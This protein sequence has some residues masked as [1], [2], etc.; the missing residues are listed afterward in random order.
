MTKLRLSVVFTVIVCITG[1]FQEIAK[2]E[3]YFG[4]GCAGSCWRP[5]LKEP[6]STEDNSQTS[7]NSSSSAERY[8]SAGQEWLRKWRK[9]VVTIGQDQQAEEQIKTAFRM[10]QSSANSDPG[11]ADAYVGMG[12]CQYGLGD[13]QGALE[14]ATR[15]LAIDPNNELAYKLKRNAIRGH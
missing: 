1:S 4:P 15:A 10:F 13:M 5:T 8:Y 14:N 3:F 11:N 6:S 2:A 9:R 12:V 7:P